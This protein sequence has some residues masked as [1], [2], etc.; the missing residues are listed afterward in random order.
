MTVARV[1]TLRL[2]LA[3]EIPDDLASIEAVLTAITARIDVAGT[4]HTNY[5]A[6][7]AKIDALLAARDRLLEQ[8]QDPGAG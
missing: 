6:A 5:D 7:H 2:L 8:Q 1:D 4:A 3:A